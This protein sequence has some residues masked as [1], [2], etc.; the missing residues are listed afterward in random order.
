MFW[1]L[2][3]PKSS[4][5]RG[6]SSGVVDCGMKNQKMVNY[7]NAAHVRVAWESDVETCAESY[8][9]LDHNPN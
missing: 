6:V 1:K 4:R 2:L 3:I 8:L 7:I 5:G 9:H